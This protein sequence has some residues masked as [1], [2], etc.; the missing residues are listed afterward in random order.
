[1]SSNE[2]FLRITYE[3]QK[4][5]CTDHNRLKELGNEY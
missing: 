4:L 5:T 1:M 2:V 3:V